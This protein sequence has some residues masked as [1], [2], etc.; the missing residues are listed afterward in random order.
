MAARLHYLL[1]K[2]NFFSLLQGGLDGDYT[3]SWMKKV[4]TSPL[5]KKKACE[6]EPTAAEHT[7][8]LLFCVFIFRILKSPKS[9]RVRSSHQREWITVPV[10]HSSTSLL[11]LLSKG[12]E[13]TGGL[14]TAIK[15][16][17]WRKPCQRAP[18]ICIHCWVQTGNE[19]VKWCVESNHH[20]HPRLPP[21]KPNTHFLTARSCKCCLWQQSGIECA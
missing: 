4:P 20:H 16:N 6:Q 17:K 5:C 10:F 18:R 1:V 15:Q 3:F 2:L 11:S 7:I 13:A 14:F 21:K 12:P 9:G 19:G 8:F